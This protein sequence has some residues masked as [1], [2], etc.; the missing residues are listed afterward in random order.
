MKQ[1]TRKILQNTLETI[2]KKESE[3]ETLNKQLRA[4][5]RKYRRLAQ[6]SIWQTLQ[7]K[8]LKKRL[9]K[10]CSSSWFSEESIDSKALII[11]ADKPIDIYTC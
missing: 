6:K 1:E 9:I 5:D 11:D 4:F 8:S 3:I 10:A 2:K 7:K